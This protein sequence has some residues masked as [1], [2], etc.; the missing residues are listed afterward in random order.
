VQR[1][2]IRGVI[3]DLDGT[4]LDSLGDIGGAMNEALEE[5]G[6][7]THPLDAYLQ[8]VGEGVE[9]LARRALP[10][11]ADVD[12]AAF[13]A[14]YRSRYA[15]RMERH[16]RPYDGIPAMLDALT[17]RGVKLAVLSNKREEFTVELVRRQLARWAFVEVRG[18][19]SGVPRKPD[20]HAAL[21]LA[22]TLGLK[23]AECAFVGDTPIDV[24]TALNAGMLPVAVLWGFRTRAELAEAGAKHTLER[25][26]E[27]LALL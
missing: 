20:P 7:P 17:A 8:M 16:T 2:V 22:Q 27:L 24:K 5:R 3:F 6:F 18:E 4:L 14:A 19:R 11:D 12:L 25:P 23:P 21:G 15:A 9:Q 1:A 13:I 26:H 10:N